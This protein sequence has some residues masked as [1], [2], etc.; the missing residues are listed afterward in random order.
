MNIFY[1]YTILTVEALFPLLDTEVK[2]HNGLL[3]FSLCGA[4]SG[5]RRVWCLYRNKSYSKFNITEHRTLNVRAC[6]G[7]HIE[8]FV[9]QLGCKACSVYSLHSVEFCRLV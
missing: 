9:I 3:K 7:L 8:A 2:S 5:M 4:F 6:F 1:C